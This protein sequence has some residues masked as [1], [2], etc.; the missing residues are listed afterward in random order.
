MIFFLIFVGL[1]VVWCCSAISRTRCNRISVKA[2]VKLSRVCMFWWMSF[3][4]V[5]VV[6]VCR[7]C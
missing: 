4:S 5:R 3:L 7:M 6:R 2:A 1:M